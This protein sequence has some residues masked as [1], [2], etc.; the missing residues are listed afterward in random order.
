MDNKILTEET[1]ETEKEAGKEVENGVSASDEAIKA[2]EAMKA[3]ASA[4]QVEE[5]VVYIEPGMAWRK[6]LKSLEEEIEKELGKANAVVADV[7]AKEKAKC[8]DAVAKEFAEKEADMSKAHEEET[9]KLTAEK[10]EAEKKLEEQHAQ[11]L[12]ELTEKYEAELKDGKEAHEA[13]LEKMKNLYDEQ[14][15]EVQEA[16][17][18]KTAGFRKEIDHYK[19]QIE[20]LM[21]HI[22]DP[23]VLQEIQMKQSQQP[24][25]KET[26]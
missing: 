5:D 2:V 11:E 18:E 22:D 7:I 26:E 9:K 16:F 19:E 8:K 10:E 3:A 15:A 21:L 23:F 14:L 13:E 12:K 4:Q 6:T 1:K 20:V 25:E 17:R 24:Q